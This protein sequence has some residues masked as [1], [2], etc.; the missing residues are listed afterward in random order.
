VPLLA[1]M[2]ALGAVPLGSLAV[3]FALESFGA[4]PTLL[5]LFGLMLAVAAVALVSPA[6]RSAP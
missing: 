4:A 5:A 3:G 6:I 1:T 2:L